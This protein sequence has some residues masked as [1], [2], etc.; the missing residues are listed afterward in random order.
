MR[1][2]KGKRYVSSVEDFEQYRERLKFLP[3]PHCHAVGYLIG[4][5]HLRG[6]GSEGHEKIRRGWR[7]FCS[8]RRRRKGCGRTYSILLAQF[9]PRHLV[10]ADTLFRFLA[11][12]R[13]GLTRKAAWERLHVPWTLQTGY[14]LWQ[15]LCGRQSPL[16]SL[17]CRQTPA[18]VCH[19]PNPLFQLIEHLTLAFSNHPCPIVAFHLHFQQPFL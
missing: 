6:Y 19:S 2:P 13:E 12:V 9:M 4:H 14:R 3:C 7:I 18:P 8:N 15:R 16:R 5:G 17:L 10:A 1:T 11:S